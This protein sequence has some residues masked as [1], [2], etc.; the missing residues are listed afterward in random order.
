[1]LL[2][3]CA[4]PAAARP[5]CRATSCGRALNL[6]S[7]SIYKSLTTCPR[8]ATSRSNATL[9]TRANASRGE[10]GLY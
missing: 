5:N 7:R 3:C 2:L 9:I 8:I 1:M 10:Q 6:M 4:T